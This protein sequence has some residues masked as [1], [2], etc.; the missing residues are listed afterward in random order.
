MV[1]HSLKAK[2]A[3]VSL[4][5]SVAYR[6][7]SERSFPLLCAGQLLAESRREQELEGRNL[8][9]SFQHDQMNH[10]WGCRTLGI[11]LAWTCG[12]L[13]D[14]LEEMIPEFVYH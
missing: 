11:K 6:S 8:S 5:L 10:M 4:N 3:V 1:P 9:R 14:V 2:S 13:R 7:L 12:N